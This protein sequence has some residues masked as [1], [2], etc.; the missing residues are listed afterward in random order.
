MCTHYDCGTPDLEHQNK[1]KR[2]IERLVDLLEYDKT[3][4]SDDLVNNLKEFKNKLKE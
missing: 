4:D 1:I 3:I 2:T